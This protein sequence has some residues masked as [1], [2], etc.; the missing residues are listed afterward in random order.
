MRQFL[1]CCSIVSVGV[2]FTVV[3]S[4]QDLQQMLTSA[5]R[6]GHGMEEMPLPAAAL[7]SW[8]TLCRPQREEPGC[9]MGKILLPVGNTRGV[10][11]CWGCSRAALR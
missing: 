6:E 1:C 10:N 7:P 8:V 9:A 5:I 11:H 2:G 4:T 3:L